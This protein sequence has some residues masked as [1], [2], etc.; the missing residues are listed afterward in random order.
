MWVTMWVVVGV[1]SAEGDAL[2]DAELIPWHRCLKMVK[3]LEAHHG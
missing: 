3:E 1:F 2:R